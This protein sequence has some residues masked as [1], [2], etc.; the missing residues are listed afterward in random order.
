MTKK[1][2]PIF[3]L[4]SFLY[5]TSFSQDFLGLSTG[6][7][8]GITGVSLQPARIVDSRHKFDINLFSTGVNYSN[9]YFLLDKNVLLKFNKNKFDDYASF[10]DEYLSQASLDAGEKAFFNIN[11][12][13]QLPLSF[14][15]GTGKKSAIALNMQFR[16][17]IQGR[18]IAQDF[19]ELAYNDFYHAPLNNTT[20]DVSGISINSLSW[21]EVGLTY[22]R[23]LISSGEHFLKG[24]ITGK[25][26]AGLSS[27]NISSNDL[28]FGVNSDSTFNFNTSNVSY[29]HNKNADFDQLFNKNFNPDA[30]AFG[31]DAG[32]VYEYRGNIDKFKYLKFDDEKSYDALRRDVNKYIFKFGV[33]LL[34]VGMFNFN[35]P[36]N[37]NSFQGNIN[38]W[39][40]RNANYNSIKNFDTALANRVLPNLNDPGNYNVYLP[41]ALS[42]QFDVKF[43]K[44]LFLNVMSYWP[45]TLGDEPGKRFN[46]Y[47]YYSITPRFETRHFGLY[48]PYTVTQRNDLSDYKQHLLGAT[49]RLGPL[50]IGSSN[51]GSMLF[52][53]KLKSADVHVGL[54]I[55]FTYGKPNK[56]NRIL[57]SVFKDKNELESSRLYASGEEDI[58]KTELE[59]ER[60]LYKEKS[61]KKATDGG[62]ILD[63]KAGK[64]YDNPGVKQN[65]TIINNYY[66]GSSPGGLVKDTIALQRNYPAY[67]PE[68]V[69][70]EIEKTMAKRD[71]VIADSISKITTDS[72]KMKKQQLDSLIQSM[73]QLQ[74][75]MDSTTR[76]DIQSGDDAA[77]Y[78][79]G[80]QRQVRQEV[81]DSLNNQNDSLRA[82]RGEALMAGTNA[83]RQ[84]SLQTE[85][86]NLKE[87]FTSDKKKVK[88]GTDSAKVDSNVGKID[89]DVD[90]LSDSVSLQ[91]EKA[92]G[93][94][95]Q[96]LRLQDSVSQLSQRYADLTDSLTRR[97]TSRVSDTSVNAVKSNATATR[98]IEQE[99][100]SQQQ[101]NRVQDSLN[102]MVQRY[103]DFTD[104]LARENMN[105][106]RKNNAD[107]NSGNKS[108]NTT[109]R[110]I[111]NRSVDSRDYQRLQEQQDALYREYA[112]QADVLSK[113]IDRLN[114]RLVQDR[115]NDRRNTNYIP[116]PLPV[117]NSRNSSNQDRL[118]PVVTNIAD[119]VYLRD[120]IILRDTVRLRDSLTKSPSDTF[121]SR[122]ILS[123]P[124]I[125]TVFVKEENKQP[126][127]DYASLPEENVLFDLGKSSVKPI[128]DNRLNFL[129]DILRK[130]PGLNVRI[131]GHTDSSGSRAINEKLSLQRAEAV[132][133]YMQEKGV[134]QNQI[135]VTSESFEN[136]A[137]SGNTRSAASQNRRVALKLEK[138]NK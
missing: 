31:F 55:G 29:N 51:L 112:R 77:V 72:L 80:L 35:K 109:S 104:S 119:T 28:R 113:D 101:V 92:S 89:S 56:S 67:N 75:E 25:Y 15:A 102:T 135:I 82:L 74:R 121:V 103:S 34:D 71:Q 69:Q 48:I 100:E 50:F 61:G 14:M 117:N 5:S 9:N 126:S 131:T 23:V 123:E 47:G 20:I 39:D 22:G 68:N 134:V 19:A 118:Q 120:S 133:K 87:T 63:Y 41:T 36:A 125:D 98:E 105:R 124:I 7:Y 111:E 85:E 4:L 49:V 108:T 97:K 37:V 83:Y 10:K 54:K 38:S 3:I 115:R 114:K 30:N 127:F 110:M 46:K 91:Q 64:V 16:T 43:V 84:D 138:L 12:R 79:N 8:S 130:N 44:G 95:E 45:V 62:V 76:A 1:I 2:L 93:R 17:M 78:Y 11:N 128:Y 58:R 90:D 40:I 18:G 32:L 122:P 52:N 70:K 42:A 96:L 132:A 21:A 33:S 66:Y 136:P 86:Q 6:N 94:Q 65:I 129:A 57:N 81:I 59:R 27:I 106:I 107:L 60:E 73:Q 137:V 13:T 53:N 88:S 24:A 26:L 99:A 116:V